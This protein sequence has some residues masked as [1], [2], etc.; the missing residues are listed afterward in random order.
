MG[1]KVGKQREQARQSNG[2]APECAGNH[3][4]DR[5]LT[6]ELAALYAEDASRPLP[7]EMSELAARLEARLKAMRARGD[8]PSQS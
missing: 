5:W 6:R 4:F 7:D 8:E 1:G 3:P 2:A